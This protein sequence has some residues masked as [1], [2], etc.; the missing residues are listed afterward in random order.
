[1][2]RRSSVISKAV[3]RINL[4]GAWSCME[5]PQGGLR[6]TQKDPEKA[7]KWYLKQKQAYS[8]VRY[9]V[10]SLP[11][12]ILAHFVHFVTWLTAFTVTTEVTVR[13]YLKKEEAA[14]DPILRAGT[15]DRQSPQ[16]QYLKELALLLLSGFTA[17]LLYGDFKSR[18]KALAVCICLLMHGLTQRVFSRHQIH[19]IIDHVESSIKDE[20]KKEK[21]KAGSGKNG[22]KTTSRADP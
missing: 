17:K 9:T 19:D 22:L 4:T 7:H 10:R 11:R 1:M 14:R 6:V 20:Q 15:E 13:T 8:K 16:P 5:T 3:K 12:S 2:V 18:S 21:K